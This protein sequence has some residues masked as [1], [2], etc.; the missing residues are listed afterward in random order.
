MPFDP[1]IPLQTQQPSIDSALK[2]ISSLLGIQGLGLQNQAQGIQNQVNQGY[3]N[4]MNALRSLVNDPSVQ[5]ANG[6]VDPGKF[7]QQAIK[8]APLLGAKTAAGG[9]VNQGQMIT[10]NSAQFKLTNEQSQKALD[11][12]TS[13]I[14][15][16]EVNAAA[17]TEKMKDPQYA[18]QAGQNLI[19]RLSDAEDQAVAMGIPK[20]VAR[21]NFA[22]LIVAATHDPVNFK[23]RLSTLMQ[24]GIGPTGQTSQNLIPA[25]N[26]DAVGTDMGGRPT[27][28][29]KN[30][31]GQVTGVHGAPVNGVVTPPQVI[32]PNETPESWQQLQNVRGAANQA[33]A[34]VP[35]QHLNNR[36]IIRILDSSDKDKLS[37]TGSNA[38]ALAKLFGGI[39]VPLDK[40]FATNA[41]RLSHY[42][43]LQTQANEKAMGVST[44]AGRSTAGLATGSIAMTPPALRTATAVNDATATG[45]DFFNRGMEAAVKGGGIGAIRDFQN[46]WSQNYDPNAMR[47]YNAGKYGDKQEINDVMQSLGGKNSAQFQ[48]L[49]RKAQNLETLSKQGHL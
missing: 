33:A 40:D 24:S 10:N 32:A 23:D 19:Q 4:D 42:L 46:A 41:N 35:N 37:P 49:L 9:I 16:P 27:V 43:A 28:T 29:Q 14:A 44:D 47:L 45:A 1:T 13:L 31:Y 30:Q 3:L 2:P 25:G 6:N 8:V 11:I 15:S 18:Q 21:A 12:G 34:T 36:E 22:P 38:G 20:T 5:D 48:A 7:A 17:D 39:G 26:R